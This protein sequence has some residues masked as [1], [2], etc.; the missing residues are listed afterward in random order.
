MGTFDTS[1]S[2]EMHAA[3]LGIGANVIGGNE[4]NVAHTD[5]NGAT[6]GDTIEITLS[7]GPVS[8]APGYGKGCKIFAP[9]EISD[10]PYTSTVAINLVGGGAVSFKEKG[11]LK[12]IQYSKTVTS[13]GIDAI[14]L[15]DR[16]LNTDNYHQP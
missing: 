4:W 15:I 3:P 11:A 6:N 9:K 14:N 16:D 2:V 10:F 8:I 7:A 12:N 1:A 5:S 13:L